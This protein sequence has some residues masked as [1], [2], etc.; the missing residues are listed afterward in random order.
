M[1]IEAHEAGLLVACRFIGPGQVIRLTDVPSAL[2]DLS[3]QAP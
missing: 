3:S 1:G 2:V